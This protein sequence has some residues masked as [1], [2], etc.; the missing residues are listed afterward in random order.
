MNY[1]VFF[2]MIMAF[3]GV[4][5]V[6]AFLARRAIFR[7]IEIF[8]QHG[9]MGINGAK[10]LQELGLQRLDFIQRIMKPRD[11]KQDALQMLI[12]KGI[13]LQNGNGKVYLD[14]GRLDETLKKKG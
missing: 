1:L 4:L 6:R 14:E 5:Y 8:R 9:A 11:Y 10:T 3:V 12:K 13:L 2:L 7:V